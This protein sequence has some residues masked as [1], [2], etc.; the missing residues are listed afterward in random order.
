MGIP[1][2]LDQLQIQSYVESTTTANKPA[3]RVANADGSKI[4][5]ALSTASNVGA[6]ASSATSVTI[7]AA[8]TGRVGF[9]LVNDSPNTLYIQYGVTASSTNYFM[10]IDP[11]DRFVCDAEL[12]TSE[13][14]SGIWTA[15]A[16]NVYYCQTLAS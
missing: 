8:T 10:R 1:N 12:V 15:A 3:V 13:Q 11:Y 6:V 4:G 5:T 16:G 9:S 14:I 2:S 7:M